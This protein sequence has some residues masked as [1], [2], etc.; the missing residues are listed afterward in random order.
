MPNITVQMFPGRPP[1][2]RRE[3]VEELTK[4]T[5]AVLGCSPG[6]VQVILVDVDPSN[7]AVGGELFADRMGKPA[8]S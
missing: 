1:E 8:E 3:L 5:C 6:A 2:K 7:W 4:T